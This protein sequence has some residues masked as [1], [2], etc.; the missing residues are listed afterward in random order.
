LAI[1][2]PTGEAITTEPAMLRTDDRGVRLEPHPLVGVTRRAV[3]LAA[4]EPGPVAP[5]AEP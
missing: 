3:Q 4:E 2:L 1:F 5:R